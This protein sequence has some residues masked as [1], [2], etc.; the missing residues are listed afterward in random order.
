MSNIINSSSYQHLVITALSTPSCLASCLPRH[1]SEVRICKSD[2]KWNLDSL[3]V[4]VLLRSCSTVHS[5]Y[6]PGIKRSNRFLEALQKRSRGYTV[7]PPISATQLIIHLSCTISVAEVRSY[8]LLSVF[9][10]PC[11]WPQQPRWGSADSRS[12]LCTHP[13]LYP[14]SDTHRAHSGVVCCT[15]QWRCRSGWTRATRGKSHVEQRNV[16]SK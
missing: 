8:W 5:V 4:H 15:S 13:A 3:W 10:F 2:S 14:T 12:C 16:S 6:P 9:R 11:W 7:N 1:C